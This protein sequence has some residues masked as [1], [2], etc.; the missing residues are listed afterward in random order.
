LSSLSPVP[1]ILTSPLRDRP[2]EDTFGPLE[3]CLRSLGTRPDVVALPADLALHTATLDDR[4]LTAFSVVFKQIT[5]HAGIE[6]PPHETKEPTPR[7]IHRQRQLEDERIRIR[8]HVSQ[9]TRDALW[10]A[11][12][13]Q[14]PQLGALHE[15]WA[16]LEELYR[17]T[18]PLEPG[19]TIVDL[20]CGQGDLARVI[21]TNLLYRSAHQGRP[22][23]PPLKYIGIEQTPETLQTAERAFQRFMQELT[24]TFSAAE[25]GPIVLV[26]Q[27]TSAHWDAPLPLADGSADRIM[28]NLFLSFV[29]SPLTAIRHALRAMSGDS[30]LTVTCFQPHTDLS[31]IYRRHLRTRGEDEFS[32]SAQIVLHYLGRLREALR[33]GLLHSFERNR[34][35]QLLIHAGAVPSHIVP[36]LDGQI[37]LAV[38]EKGKSA[39]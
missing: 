38:A 20:G 22:T 8:H 7:D 1:L 5:A 16:L 18:L 31:R 9:A 11:R 17:R 14:L 4:H 6:Q 37:L 12:L 28:G 24:G 30:I 21:Q 3:P 23:G 19:M 15:Y 34:L 10:V 36:L 26:P 25:S 29:P 13:A 35:G 32:P 27:W 33:H 39:G 2:R